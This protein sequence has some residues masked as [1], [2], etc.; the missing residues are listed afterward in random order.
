MIRLLLSLIFSIYLMFDLHAQ[1]SD[2]VNQTVNGSRHGYWVITGGMIKDKNYVPIAKV[3]EGRFNY[4]RRIGEWNKYYPS[5]K[6]KSVSID[7]FG[8]EILINSRISLL[9]FSF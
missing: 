4:G 3:E 8:L 7:G 5:G 2:S 9:G 1:M 6:I